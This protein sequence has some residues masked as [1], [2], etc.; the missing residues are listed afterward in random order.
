MKMTRFMLVAIA[1]VAMA[2]L[3]TPRAA[4]A[5]PNFVVV[6][7]GDT[8]AGIAARAG[9]SLDA[10]LRVNAIPNPNF[11]Y[12]GQRL[13]IPGSAPAPAKPAP[14]GNVYVVNPGDTLGTIAARFGTTLTLLMR[15]NGLANPNFVYVGQRLN[16][17]GKSAPAPA[18]QPAPAPAPLPIPGTSPAPPSNGR[19]IDVNISKQTITAYESS[20]PLKSV[21]VSTG[22]AWYPTPAGRFK[23]YTKIP[24]QTMS[25]GVGADRYYLPGVPWVMYFTGAYAIH[26]TYWHR[27]FGQPMSHGCVNLSIEDAKW[28][29]EFAAVGTPVVSH[30]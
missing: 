18:P 24:A 25:G 16:V 26:G 22:L 7:W 14:T 5:S 15:A 28:F 23:V 27:N 11:V 10:L 4:A 21:L 13:V 17:P 12:A 19:W 20:T 3:A 2:G 29:Y 6:R 1:L 8:L 9:V 30:Y